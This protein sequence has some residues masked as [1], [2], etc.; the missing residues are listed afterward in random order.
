[1]ARAP[2]SQVS[3]ARYAQYTPL[4]LYPTDV[5]QILD[6]AEGK[7]VWVDCDPGTGVCTIEIQDFFVTFV[8]PCTPA[9]C[10]VEG[11]TMM[12]GGCC[13]LLI[14]VHVRLAMK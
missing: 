1:M 6:S 11:Y 14:F 9:E 2:L 12:E 5:Q 4:G 13:L 10:L 8:A 7:P 3:V